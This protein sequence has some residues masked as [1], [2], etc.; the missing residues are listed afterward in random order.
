GPNDD[1]AR[2]PALVMFGLVGIGLPAVLIAIFADTQWWRGE[3]A[4]AF[5]GLLAGLQVGL[6][7]NFGGLVL[8]NRGAQAPDEVRLSPW[9]MLLA[10]VLAVLVGGAVAALVPRG[11]GRP[12]PEVVTPVALAPS[13]RASWFGRGEM[14]RM[15]T[16][17]MAAGV[18]VL[19]VA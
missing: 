1:M 18:L 2:A 14:G 17:L 16:L 11:T 9:L 15:A 8:V 3:Y 5:A 4:R 13:A 10:L 19:V 12:S 7:T 6:T